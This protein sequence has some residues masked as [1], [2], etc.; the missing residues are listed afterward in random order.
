MD[1]GHVVRW[2]VSTVWPKYTCSR[3]PEDQ[4]T[5]Q[6]DPAWFIISRTLLQQAERESVSVVIVMADTAKGTFVGLPSSDERATIM[7]GWE[8]HRQSRMTTDQGVA[9]YAS[10]QQSFQNGYFG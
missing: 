2:F 5:G 10:C 8:K 1:G 7:S 4:Q 3:D 6:L 9:G